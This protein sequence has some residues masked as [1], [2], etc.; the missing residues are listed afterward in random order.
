MSINDLQSSTTTMQSAINTGEISKSMMS[1]KILGIMQVVCFLLIIVGLIVGI[2]YIIKSKKTI[3]KKIIIGLIIIIIPIIL[4]L[5]VTIIKFNIV[6]NEKNIQSNEINSSTNVSNSTNNTTKNDKI[7]DSML[8]LSNYKNMPAQKTKCTLNLFGSEHT[9]GLVAP[10]E[11]E[12]LNEF[13]ATY[14]YN[15]YKLSDSI[16]ISELN[17]INDSAVSTVSATDKYDSFL[18][19]IELYGEGLSFKECI[20]QGKFLIKTQGDITTGSFN[21]SANQIGLNVQNEDK[22]NASN[23]LDAIIDN[24]GSPTYIVANEDLGQITLDD[25]FDIEYKLI[26]EYNEY[27]IA[28]YV[29]EE[30]EENDEK[31]CAIKYMYYYPIEFFKQT[32]VT[33]LNHYKYK[34]K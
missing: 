15:P 23:T 2:L 19:N 9:K 12:Q 4:N 27:A 11:L 1:V 22:E 26:Y 16:K 34:L 33:E 32:D 7:V 14:K 31:S 8:W 20:E 25:N 18:F 17:N 5:I 28:F 13:V 30:L 6:L 24:L 29:E 10:I 3:A 21:I